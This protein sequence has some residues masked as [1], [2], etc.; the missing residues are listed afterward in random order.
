MDTKLFGSEPKTIYPVR[1]S[2]TTVTDER[3]LDGR[4]LRGCRLRLLRKR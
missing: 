2:L 4:G 3:A 1:V